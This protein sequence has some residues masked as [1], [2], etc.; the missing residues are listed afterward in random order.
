[1]HRKGSCTVDVFP[2]SGKQNLYPPGQGELTSR[3][4]SA[5][6]AVITSRIRV[7]RCTHV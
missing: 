7:Q 4:A 6:L 5:R 3:N 1:M 2:L